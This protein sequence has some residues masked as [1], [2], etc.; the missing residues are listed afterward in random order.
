MAHTWVKACLEKIGLRPNLAS[1]PIKV[2]EGKCFVGAERDDVLVGGSKV[3]GAAQRRTKK[4][5]L[6]QGSIQSDAQRL[7]DR[8]EWLDLARETAKSMWSCSFFDWQP[9][10][11]HL[12]HVRKLEVEK[13]GS[14]EFNQKR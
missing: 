8:S 2:G 9:T 1:E 14:I 3:A 12:E 6:I 4:G 11:D 7:I 10:K 5:L 13:Y